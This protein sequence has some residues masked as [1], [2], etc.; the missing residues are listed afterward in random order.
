MVR[1]CLPACM[2]A[3]VYVWVRYQAYVYIFGHWQVCAVGALV[4]VE[5]G[6]LNLTDAVIRPPMTGSMRT[7]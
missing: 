5:V 2:R 1:A 4:C 7:L 3:F 6:R